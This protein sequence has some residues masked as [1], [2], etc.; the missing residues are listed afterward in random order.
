MSSLSAKAALKKLVVKQSSIIG[1][2]ERR[3]WHS[4]T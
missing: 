3:K 2:D 4:R 1:T